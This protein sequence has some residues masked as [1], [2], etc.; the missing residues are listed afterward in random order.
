MDKSNNSTYANWAIYSEELVLS[1]NG[2][3]ILNDINFKLSKSEFCFLI[4]KSGSGKS[5]LLKALIG[6]HPIQA[7]QLHVLGH[8]LNKIKLDKLYPLRRQ[9][10][11]IFQEFHLLFDRNVFDNLAF[12]LQSTGRKVNNV[13]I[14]QQLFK[15]GLEGK[16]QMMPFHLSGGE[17]QR[18]AIARALINNPRLIIADEPT[19]NLDPETAHSIIE[20]LKNIA[21]DSDCAV[22]IA[23][24]NF[25]MIKSYPTRIVEIEKTY[26]KN[27]RC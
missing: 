19:G 10:G 17:Q 25:D 9:M 6:A 8:N 2:F 23:T 5:T 3:P 24:H 15:V 21:R 13:D 14:E 20:L 4:G 12:V 27:V 11:V 7:G 26:L 1:Q 18:L 22:L 16:N